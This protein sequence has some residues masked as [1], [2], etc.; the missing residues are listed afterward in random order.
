MTDFLIKSRALILFLI[1]VSVGFI[2]L[3]LMLLIRYGSNDFIIQFANHA[4]PFSIVAVVCVV[5]L[6]IFNLYSARFNRNITEFSD[7]FIKSILVSLSISILIFYVY[8]EFF[9]LTPK[10]NLVIFTALFGCIDFSIRILVRRYYSRRKINRTVV[11]VGNTFNHL[12][13]EIKNNQ[14]I[15]YEITKEVPTFDYNEIIERDP[16]IVIV[17]SMEGEVFDRLYPLL[18]NHISVYTIEMFYVETFQKIPIE[19]I[20]KNKIIEYVSSNGALFTFLKRCIDLVMALFFIIVTLPLCLLI[21]LLI[22]ITSHGPIFIRQKR[23]G[24][25]D[26]IF[27]LFKFRSMIATDP[28]GQSE[29]GQVQWTKNDR[30]D[31]RITPLGR[32]LRKTHLDEIPQLINILQGTISFVG[33]RPERP[34]F[35]KMLSE[36]IA[37]YDLRHSVKPGLTGW[38]QINYR[39]GSSIEDTKE[40]LKFDFYYIKNRNIFLDILIII[41]TA[42]MVLMRH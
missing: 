41:K 7:S 11:I 5:S 26:S 38:A 35:T 14:T 40:K 10:T 30:T 39:Y 9:N 16:D 37:Y 29:G 36:Q 1:D 22:K 17:D 32:I 13:E 2:A 6:Y 28:D 31:S 18:K 8:G 19:T 20:D 34:E 15:G 25:N 23:I 12:K 27:T 24:K 3:L 42:A 4:M 33:P 21:A